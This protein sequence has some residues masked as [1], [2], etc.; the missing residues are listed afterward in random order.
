MG[1]LRV[2]TQNKLTKS[3]HDNV[4]GTLFCETWP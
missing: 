4:N 2:M 1:N 3:N